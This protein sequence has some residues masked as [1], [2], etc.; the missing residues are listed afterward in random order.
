MVSHFCIKHLTSS[1]TNTHKVTP[2]KT[3]IQNQTNR[4]G[5]VDEC[6]VL[7]SVCS[8]WLFG[9]CL[10]PSISGKTR[11]QSTVLDRILCSL[12][13][14]KGVPSESGGE[15]GDSTWSTECTKHA[16]IVT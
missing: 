8:K 15:Y 2:H 1:S 14:P 6:L 10:F 12:G 5:D 13:D 16:V 3:S 11:L 9:V 7:Y 4:T